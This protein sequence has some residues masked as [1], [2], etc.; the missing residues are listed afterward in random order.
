MNHIEILS[1]AKKGIA[2]VILRLLLR[3]VSVLYGVVTVLRNRLYDLHILRSYKVDIP[4][5]CVGNITAGGTGK[6]PMVAWLCEY[7]CSKGASPALLS[8]GYKSSD[9]SGL[10]DEMRLLQDALPGVSFYVG[11]NRAENAQRAQLDGATIIVMDDGY[12]HRRLVR[13]LNIL[14]VDAMCPFGFGRILPAG[15]LRESEVGIERAGAAVIS[16]SDM[17]SESE[18]VEIERKLLGYREMPIALGCHEPS[19][20]YS[21]TGSGLSLSELK[22][23]K[24]TAFCSIGNPG[25]FIATLEKLGADIRGRYFFDDHSDYDA[26][27]VGIIRQLMED[28]P[29]H[30]FI[31]TEKDWVKLRELPEVS[32]LDKLFWLKIKMSFSRGESELKKLVDNITNLN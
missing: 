20:L 23:K 17:A 1:G 11:S 3:A 6:T 4:V 21:V 15:L 22:G 31:T 18:L 26:E 10:N 28:V 7:L 8:R 12:Q 32:G 24:V 13:D 16:R 25:G 9:P 2:A 5:I 19:E 27:R 14:M 30:W 29:D